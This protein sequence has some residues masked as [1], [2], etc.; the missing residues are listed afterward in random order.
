MVKVND[1]REFM[2]DCH[3]DDIGMFNEAL[4]E[5]RGIEAEECAQICDSWAE[6]ASRSPLV[7]DERD[8]RA[9]AIGARACARYI[10]AR[11]GR[12]YSW[13]RRQPTREEARLHKGCWRVMVKGT[14][15]AGIALAVDFDGA[16]DFGFMRCTDGA[17]VIPHDDD[18]WRPETP[19][20]WPAAWPEENRS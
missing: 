2:D 17:R 1:F 3:F 5:T 7:A 15:T 11:I 10:R 19:D 12:D 13:R 18:L 14:G 20:G 9:A 4:T 8:M 16:G 6:D